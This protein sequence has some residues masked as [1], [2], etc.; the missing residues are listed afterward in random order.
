MPRP[1]SVAI[2]ATCPHCGEEVQIILSKREVKA[3]FKG[4]KV[5]IRQAQIVTEKALRVEKR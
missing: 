3:L 5:D 2:S 1:K 4:F